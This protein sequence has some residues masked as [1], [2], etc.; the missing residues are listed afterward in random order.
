[1]VDTVSITGAIDAAGFRAS[2]ASEEMA[3]AFGFNQAVEAKVATTLPLDITLGGTTLTI[4]DSAGVVR[5]GQLFYVSPT[6]V[7]F[8]TPADMAP[9]PGILEITNAQG[10][11]GSMPVTIETAAPGLFSADQNGKGTAAAVVQLYAADGT[12]S[13]SLA[14][15]CDGTGPCSPIA[16]DVANA[17]DQVFLSLYGTGI[18]G[19]SKTG[20]VSVAIGGI[21]VDVLFA[22]A[23]PQFPGLDQVNV[24]L[25]P[26]F[27]GKGDVAVTVTVDGHASNSVSIRIR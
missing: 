6:Q 15:N 22:G 1:M 2:L 8:V 21:P 26:A 14:A 3:T 16:I 4:T 25:S 12:I 13:T 20:T 5:A 19:A 24:K 27:A 11:K 7:N 18:R 10:Q 9:G 23:Q 17:T